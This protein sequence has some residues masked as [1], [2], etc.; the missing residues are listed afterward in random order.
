VDVGG[1]TLKLTS[2]GKVAFYILNVRQGTRKLYVYWESFFFIITGITYNFQ[3]ILS[4]HV[5]HLGLL[6][7]VHLNPES[8]RVEKLF[9]S[10]MMSFG[11]WGQFHKPF[12]GSKCTGKFMLFLEYDTKSK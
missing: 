3:N 7:K 10:H 11:T 5:Q 2:G 6:V 4:K 1:N 8:H 9:Q 12:Y